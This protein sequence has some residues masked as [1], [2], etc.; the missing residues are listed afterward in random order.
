VI[1][2]HFAENYEVLENFSI[3]VVADFIRFNFEQALVKVLEVQSNH[4]WAK[5]QEFTLHNQFQV[6]F[7]QSFN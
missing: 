1:N 4:W 7:A 6:L 2:C 5:I 3:Q